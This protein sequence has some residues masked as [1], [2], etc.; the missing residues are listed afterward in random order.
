[1]S[2]ARKSRK[3]LISAAGQNF[4]DPEGRNDRRRTEEVARGIRVSEEPANNRP[5][6]WTNPAQIWRQK[7]RFLAYAEVK[8]CRGGS[9]LPGD[10]RVG[11]SYA[12]LAP[13]GAD[14]WVGHGRDDHESG[15]VRCI[16][17]NKRP[18][19]MRAR[20]PSVK[21]LAQAAPCHE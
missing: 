10:V 11:D 14:C 20:D 7:K 1:V 2:T 16:S 6:A 4:G 15:F 12:R 17:K 18:Q 8:E 13:M 19:F 9:I 3:F 5:D 21:R